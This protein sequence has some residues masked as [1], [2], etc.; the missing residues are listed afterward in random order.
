L[1]TLYVAGA[2]IA[3]AAGIFAGPSWALATNLAPEAEGALYLGLA[4]GATVVGSMGGRLGGGLIDVVNQ[5][6]GTAGLGYTVNFG[7]AA[8]FFAASSLV[9]LKIKV[10]DS[11]TQ[12]PD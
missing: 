1:N 7:I 4:N 3:V 10:P 2:L 5:L 12:N 11:G 8:L 9:A 6:S